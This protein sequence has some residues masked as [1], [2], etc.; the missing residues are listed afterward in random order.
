[1][2]AAKIVKIP[3]VKGNTRRSLRLQWQTTFEKEREWHEGD[4]EIG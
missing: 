1:M 2:M 3:I 4:H